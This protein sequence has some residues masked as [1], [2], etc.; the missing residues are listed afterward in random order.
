MGQSAD[1]TRR[2]FLGATAG[3]VCGLACGNSAQLAAA[4]PASR[5]S[6]VFGK[7]KSVVVLYLYG[8]PSQ[9]DTLDPKPDAPL[10]RRGDFGSIPT[11]L[12]GI[13]ACEHLPRIA[14][15]IDR[16][17]L[18]R[19]MSHSSNNHAVSVALS[20]L[21]RS[22][23]A[24]EANRTDAQHWPYFGSVLEYLWKQRGHDSGDTGLPVNVILPWPLNARKGGNHYR[25]RVP[26]KVPVREFWSFTV[27]SLETSSFFLNST[28]LT[29][30]SLDKE[31]KKNDD[32]SVDIYIG[33]KPP[34]G[35][36][37][38]WL[39]SPPGQ[40]WFPWFRVYG[41]EKAI[42]DKSWKLPDIELVK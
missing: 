5:R 39:Y 16:M 37:S 10:E 4:T 7:A 26:A 19:S 30:S 15:S 32:G 2:R 34:V 25:L 21:P 14:S 9:M 31:L 18:V 27:Y 20:G 12:A 29:L 24:I 6:R 13:R 35:Q 36:E 11:R 22:E 1:L 3:G 40:K 42:L 33:P 41:P 23:P 17:C 8:A 38:N 28:R